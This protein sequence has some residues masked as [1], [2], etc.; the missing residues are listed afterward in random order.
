MKYCSWTTPGSVLCSLVRIK[1]H[2]WCQG[3]DLSQTLYKIPVPK[4]SYFNKAV[5]LNFYHRELKVLAP[6]FKSKG[7]SIVH[8][9][10]DS[11]LCS[12]AINKAETPRPSQ[13]WLLGG[14]TLH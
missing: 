13:I 8:P 4:C 12:A 2:M 14:E 7:E 9:I 3:L 11:L 1:G 5:G 6:R 10:W